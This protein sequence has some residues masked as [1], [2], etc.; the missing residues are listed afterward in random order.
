MRWALFV[1]LAAW[2]VCGGCGKY[3]PA[4]MAPKTP[5]QPAAAQ[6]PAPKPQQPVAPQSGMTAG[7]QGI[8]TAI[9]MAPIETAVSGPMGV[10][11]ASPSS[12]PPSAP[13]PAVKAD[14]GVGAK[15]RGY[16][17]GII[18]TPVATYFRAKE[19]IAFRIQI[20]DAMRLYKATNGSAPKTHEEFME[21]II[22]ENR[23]A[24]PEL[25]PGHRY[26]YYPE[27][28]EL[29]VEQPAP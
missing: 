14:A 20:P 9:G 5:P 24:L 6:A 25:P 7:M 1:S 18:T 22:K 8:G 4:P 13:P 16:G 23:I 3:E 10:A 21:K 27:Q 26:R 11:P 29:M 2:V 17:P 12:P 15:G 19:Q 28:E